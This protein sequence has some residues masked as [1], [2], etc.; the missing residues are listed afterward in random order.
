MGELHLI[1]VS[2]SKDDKIS[3]KPLV[4]LENKRLNAI[5][6]DYIR[7]S[8][9][10]VN[11]IKVYDHD[12]ICPIIINGYANGFLIKEF[13]INELNNNLLYEIP[14]FS[15][16]ITIDMGILYNINNKLKVEQLLS[17]IIN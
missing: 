15:K 7:N 10:S 5:Y 14:L 3:D 12:N 11:K 6:D 1:F 9:I 4:M 2:N 8:N 17:N 13:V 16:T